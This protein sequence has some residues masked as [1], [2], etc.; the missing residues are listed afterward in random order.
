MLKRLALIS[1]ISLIAV[2]VIFGLQL[3]FLQPLVQLAPNVQSPEEDTPPKETPVSV[4]DIVQTNKPAWIL[5]ET[6]DGAFITNADGTNLTRLPVPATQRYL[7][8]SPDGQKVAFTS[9]EAVD[10]FNLYVMDADGANVTRL[11]DHLAEDQYPVWSPDGRR[12]AFTS[13]VLSNHHI[14]VVNR[15]GTNLIE[16]KPDVA[17]DTVS[18]SGNQA[19]VWSPNGQKIGFVSNQKQGLQPYIIDADGTDPVELP[20]DAG[21]TFDLTWS[22]DGRQVAFSSLTRPKTDRHLYVMDADG[23]DKTNL[24]QGSGLTSAYAIMWSP[25][26]EQI[27]F[28]SGEMGEAGIYVI[29]ADGTNLTRLTDEAMSA[30]Y[31]VWS[32]DGQQIAFAVGPDVDEARLYVMNA[33]G[34]NVTQLTDTPALI[35]WIEWLPPAAGPRLLV[36]NSGNE[37][38]E[39]EE[40]PPSTAVPLAQL[41]LQPEDLPEGTE[42][43][44]RG[45][46][47]LAS[48][49][50]PLFNNFTFDE[51]AISE[52]YHVFALVPLPQLGSELATTTSVINHV[53]R[54]SSP[55]QAKAQWESMVEALQNN[56]LRELFPSDSSTAE[57]ISR[58]FMTG[59]VG[60]EGEH[61]YWGLIVNQNILNLLVF[62][63]IPAVTGEPNPLSREFFLSALDKLQQHMDLALASSERKTRLGYGIQTNPWGDTD[64]NINHLKTLGFEWVKFQ[65][66]WKE[67]E[68]T[69]GAYDWSRWDEVIETYAANNIKVLLSIPKAPDWARPADDDKTIEGPPADPATYA[70][71]VAKVAERYR[72]QVQAIEVWNE[73]NLWYEAGG[74]GRIDAARYVQLLQQAYQAIKAVNPEMTVVS[75]GLTP[76][77]TIEDLAVDDVEYLEQMYANGLKGYFDA[78][79]A[80]PAGFNCPA[81]ADWQTITSEE[82]TATHFLEPFE[83]R[84]H[85]WCFLGTMAAYREVMIANGDENKPIWPTEFGWAV[86]QNSASGF[87]YARDNTAEEQTAWTLAAFE[88]AA[89]QEWVGPMFLWNLDYGVNGN[90]GEL[91]YFSIIGQPVYEA[92]ARDE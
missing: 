8:W 90:Y 18:G 70:G 61:V 55:E 77:G 41:A 56:A 72:G 15:D 9:L 32:P 19:P 85:G 25:K 30:W 46:I 52:N 48:P 1:S 4:G 22:P 81:L 23:T 78:L 65:M 31:G 66:A 34:S 38:P 3:G 74:Q 27:L 26:G 83:N 2:L 7:R 44:S 60:D 10:V 28:S 58:V 88:W 40:T 47:I 5:F 75:G 42:W 37:T 91:G 36:D 68:L 92:L 73:Q 69:P 86:A 59:L 12:I 11:T 49:G 63:H 35:S 76:A 57:E 79:G 20:D 67:V 45:P 84:H 89:E 80:H 82:A 13:R 43:Q 14:Y 24:T 62:D 29:N 64:A 87:E 16:L 51:E 71:F 17:E 6:N 21:M 33:D 53:Y 50:N 54:Y 39:L